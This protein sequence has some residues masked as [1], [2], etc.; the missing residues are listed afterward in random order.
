ML[1]FKKFFL[2]K[3]IFLPIFLTKRPETNLTTVHCSSAVPSSIAFWHFM[4][5]FHKRSSLEIVHQLLLQSE[6]EIHLG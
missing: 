4:D 2:K 6:T 1:I 5:R 3:G